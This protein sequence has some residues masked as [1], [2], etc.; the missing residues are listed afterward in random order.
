MKAQ[1][2]VLLEI[3]DLSIEYRTK[4]G[5]LQAVFE[6]SLSI[7]YGQSVAVIGESGC[8]KT[9][10]ATSIVQMLSRNAAISSGTVLFRKKGEEGVVLNHLNEKEMRKLRWSN[11][12]MMFQASQSS[13]NPVTKIQTQFIDT[14]L[15]HDPHADIQEVLKRSKELLELVYLD[16]DTALNAYPHELSGGMKQRTLIALSLLLDP[17]LVILDEPTTAL[18]LITQKKILHLLNSLRSSKGF[19]MMFITHDLGIVTQLADRVVTMYAGAVVE[20]AP[21]K[22]F[23]SDPQHPYSKGLL[24]AIPSLDA[25]FE[26]LY[27]I[28]GSTP[29]LVEKIKGCLFAPRCEFAFDRCTK[30][31]PQLRKVGQD[32]WAACHLLKEVS[33]VTH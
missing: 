20:N 32:R 1:E 14:A 24:K 18:D 26:Q 6:A 21:T 31:V 11:I 29:D 2:D 30:E 9:T 3:Q 13:F 4:R 17:Q 15:A 8:G 12:V 19:S 5:K 7:G 10:L 28:P 27:S 25:S 23:F 33:D 16:S 22:A